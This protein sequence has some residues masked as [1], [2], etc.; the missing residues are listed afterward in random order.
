MKTCSRDEDKVLNGKIE[1]ISYKFPN[2]SIYIGYCTYGLDENYRLHKKFGCSLICTL[3]NEIYT[4][5]K[6]KL[7]LTVENKSYKEIYK[8]CREIFDAN[9]NMKILNENLWLYGYGG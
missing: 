6:P 4:N 2:N 1:I 7:E 5:V 8:I 9:P 3:L